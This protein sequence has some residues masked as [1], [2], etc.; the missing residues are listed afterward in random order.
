LC[1]FIVTSSFNICKQNYQHLLGRVF[2]PICI[3]FSE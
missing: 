3:V 2:I 1:V